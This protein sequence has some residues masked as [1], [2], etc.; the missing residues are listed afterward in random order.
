MA[1]AILSSRGSGRA[2]R[3]GVEA[4][5]GLFQEGPLLGKRGRGAQ[6]RQGE[7]SSASLTLPLRL[8]WTGQVCLATW[9]LEMRWPPPRPQP[10]SYDDG[11]VAPP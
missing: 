1:W 10:V 11:E 3:E 2:L 6:V 4:L 8:R 7:E 5:V 9:I